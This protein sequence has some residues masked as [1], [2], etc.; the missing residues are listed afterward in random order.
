MSEAFLDT[1][2]IIRFVAGDDPVKQAAA[3]VLFLQVQAETITLRAPDTVVADA[4]YVLSSSRLYRFPRQRIRAELSTLLRLS[5]L[6]VH[7]RRL[8]LRAL[9][10]Y[11]A[12]TLDFGDAMIVATAERR[13]GGEL[14]SYDRDFD[15]QPG[16]RRREP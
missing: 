12:T 5:H 9:D 4:V 8:L 2:V 11:A 15:T 3:A 7:N 13:G 16:V 10:I 1:D 6:R 14:Y